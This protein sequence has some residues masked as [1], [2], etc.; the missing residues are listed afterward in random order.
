MYG[1]NSTLSLAS[2]ALSAESGALAITNN[3]INNVNTPGY[4][5][6]LVNFSAQ[7]IAGDATQTQSNGVSFTGF[8][9]VRDQVLNLTIQQK[10]ADVG[11][12]NTQSAA[13]GQVE[14]G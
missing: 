14:A 7:A 13:W 8:T 9:S 2:H 4:S 3:N 1:L 6:E 5:R 10:T 12:L 11:S